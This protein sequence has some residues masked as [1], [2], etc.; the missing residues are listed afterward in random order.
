[1][2]DATDN[3]DYINQEELDMRSPAQ[4]RIRQ[5]RLDGFNPDTELRVWY[6]GEDESGATILLEQ[7]NGSMAP[8]SDWCLED[9][10]FEMHKLG[11]SCE[12]HTVKDTRGKF[13]GVISKTDDEIVFKPEEKK[14]DVLS[15]YESLS[16]GQKQHLVNKIYKE[17][18]IYAQKLKPLLPFVPSLEVGDVCRVVGDL[19]DNPCEEGEYV[20]VV[21]VDTG[22]NMLPYRCV[23]FGTPGSTWL[24]ESWLNK[25]ED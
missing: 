18:R 20:K 4:Q 14:M 12:Y 24:A 19:S 13:L 17:D 1:M 5:M 25:V 3:A 7:A 22:D 15:I 6:D 23:S 21:E 11:F 2:S 16:E 8:L 10:V 9:M